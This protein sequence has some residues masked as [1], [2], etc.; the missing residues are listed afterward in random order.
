MPYGR[1]KELIAQLNSGAWLEDISKFLK[2]AQQYTVNLYSQELEHLR[3]DN[4][5]VVHLDGMIYELKEN[6]YS[7][8]YGVDLK[9][10]AEWMI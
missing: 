2:Q 7:D 1:G 6:W 8:E 9:G 3:R 5:I 10:R 4:A